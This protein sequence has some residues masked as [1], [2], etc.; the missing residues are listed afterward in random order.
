M[1]LAEQANAVKF[2]IRDRD[3][4]FAG[5]FDAFFAAEGIRI[6]KTLVLAPRANAIAERFVGTPLTA[7][8]SRTLDERGMY[9]LGE[10]WSWPRCGVG[11]ISSSKHFSVATAPRGVYLW[12]LAW[13]AVEQS[14][15]HTR[16]SERG[17]LFVELQAHVGVSRPAFPGFDGGT[18]GSRRCPPLSR[19]P[20]IRRQIGLRRTAGERAQRTFLGFH[21]ERNAIS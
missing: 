13:A 19:M 21:E 14:Y 16:W 10:L 2:L 17:L 11:V 5:S 8:R 7:L 4:K 15:G 18:P 9:R 12:P 3:T 20:G 1:E 6:I